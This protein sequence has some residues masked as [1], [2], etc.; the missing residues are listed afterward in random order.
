M[1]KLGDYHYV[2]GSSGDV[3]AR[4]SE[5]TMAMVMVV[6]NVMRQED[7]KNISKN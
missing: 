3:V 4:N 1:G 2:D 6:R 5:A 7:L